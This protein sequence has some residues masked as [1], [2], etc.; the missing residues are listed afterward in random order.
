VNLSYNAE[1][2]VSLFSQLITFSLATEGANP[3]HDVIHSSLFSFQF[4]L[5]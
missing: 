4:L 5:H 2:I 1:W 3:R